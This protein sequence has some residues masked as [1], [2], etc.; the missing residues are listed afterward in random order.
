M[1]VHYNCNPRNKSVGDCAIR[2]ISAATGKT[3]EEIYTD[4]ALYGFAFG[5]LPNADE[6][7]GRYLRKNGFVRH[8]IPDECPDCYTVD[9]FAQDHKNG[10]YVLSM[11]GRHV[12]T[13]IDGNYLDSWDSGNE[14]PT[15]YF[16]K[17]H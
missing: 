8:W 10:V 15:Y 7:W 17:E 9:K 5:D 2:A 4:L 6:V 13:V 14:V 3:W 1:Y 11:P 16:E 12:V